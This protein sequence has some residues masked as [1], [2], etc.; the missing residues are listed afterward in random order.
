MTSDVVV[1]DLMLPLWEEVLWL[2]LDAWDGVRLP[3]TASQWNVPGR[4]GRTATS[5]SSLLL[6]E[7]V[8]L[9]PSIR[10]H[11]ELQRGLQLFHRG[12]EVSF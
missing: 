1:S 11:G 5:S 2:F 7:L 4:Y 12:S 9:G 10:P 6:R 8:R 3:T